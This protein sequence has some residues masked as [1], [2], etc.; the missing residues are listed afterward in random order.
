MHMVDPNMQ[1]IKYMHV[2]AMLV[3]ELKLMVHVVMVI[4]IQELLSD[5]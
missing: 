5:L 1:I 4:G 2:K 3:M